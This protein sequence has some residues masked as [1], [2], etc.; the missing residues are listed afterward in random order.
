MT[1]STKVKYA[2]GYLYV[3]VIQWYA[4]AMFPETLNL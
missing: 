2:N 1:G 3:L 4:G